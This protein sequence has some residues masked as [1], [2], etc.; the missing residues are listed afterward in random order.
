MDFRQGVRD[1]VKNLPGFF[2]GDPAAMI[3]QIL[4]QTDALHIFHDKIS[5][6]RPGFFKIAVDLYNIGISDEF[7]ESPGFFQKLLFSILEVLNVPVALGHH[8]MR[9]YPRHDCRRIILLDRDC[10]V[11]MIVKRLISD[12]ETALP[13]DV[14]D[15]IAAVQYTVLFQGIWKGSK[16]H[17]NILLSDLL[18][19]FTFVTFFT[20]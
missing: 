2:P 15:N 18:F 6:S 12:P 16:T 9:G 20:L 17:C 14:S 3:L 7:R 19:S 5:G 11:C 1:G 4:C 13:Q 10:V 8:G